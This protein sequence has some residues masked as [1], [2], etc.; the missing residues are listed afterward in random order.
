MSKQYG[1]PFKSS[2]TQPCVFHTCADVFN[3]NKLATSFILI[4]L[5]KKII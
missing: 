2:A 1:N 3:I 5:K 4:N